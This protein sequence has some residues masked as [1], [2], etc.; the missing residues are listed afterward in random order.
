MLDHR[1]E[2][3][4][5]DLRLSPAGALPGAIDNELIRSRAACH[6]PSIG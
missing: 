6:S 1:S 5:N 3:I 2:Q 4:G